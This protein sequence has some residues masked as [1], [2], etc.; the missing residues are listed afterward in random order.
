MQARVARSAEA[1]RKQARAVRGWLRGRCGRERGG[2]FGARCLALSTRKV[3]DQIAV[4]RITLHVPLRPLCRRRAK[5][6]EAER[7]KRVVV[8]VFVVTVVRLR[9]LVLAPALAAAAPIVTQSDSCTLAYL[10]VLCLH[11]PPRRRLPIPAAV[12]RM[13][14]SLGGGRWP[15]RGVHHPRS[16]LRVGAWH[17]VPRE[18]SGAD[19]AIARDAEGERVRDDEQPRAEER[20]NL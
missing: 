2:R 10:R 7:L 15:T 14:R 6:T 8:V 9:H 18:Y 19:V 16:T 13:L 11:L 4:H 20:G 17:P 3:D 5:S 12:A 1:E